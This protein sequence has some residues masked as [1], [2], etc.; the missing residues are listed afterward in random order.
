[1]L[2]DFELHQYIIV[3]SS[4]L[5]SFQ[6]RLV[7]VLFYKLCAIDQDKKGRPIEDNLATEFWSYINTGQRTRI[8]KLLLLFL[9]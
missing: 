5:N 2:L 6:I 4:T 7:L 3:S 9:I 8:A 1:M